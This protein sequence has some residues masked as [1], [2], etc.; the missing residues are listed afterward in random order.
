[1]HADGNAVIDRD[2][3]PFQLMST[4][5][6]SVVLHTWYSFPV[7]YAYKVATNNTI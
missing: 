1:M 4:D 2:T 7:I 6:G 5:Q 3:F